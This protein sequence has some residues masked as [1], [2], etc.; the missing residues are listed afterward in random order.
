MKEDFQEVP[1]IQKEDTL[2]E[3]NAYRAPVTEK[4][5]TEKESKEDSN[6]KSAAGTQS[7]APMS[8]AKHVPIVPLRSM[9]WNKSCVQV[10]FKKDRPT[11]SIRVERFLRNRLCPFRSMFRC[12]LEAC[13]GT[14]RLSNFCQRSPLSPNSVLYAKIMEKSFEESFL[15][16]TNQN[17]DA[18][19]ISLDLWHPVSFLWHPP[20]L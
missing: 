20:Y 2:E 17:F 12:P 4:E 3:E 13:S 9:F 7:K 6:R 11:Q 10:I 18:R 5:E 15:E 14:S 8:A 16:Q 1:P 19:D